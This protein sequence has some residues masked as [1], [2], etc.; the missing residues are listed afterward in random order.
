MLNSHLEAILAELSVREPIFHRREFGTSRED[1][2]NMTADDFWEIGASGAIYDRGY[3]IETLLERYQSP[4]PDDLVCSDFT[5]R[6]LAQDLYQL[7]YVL[8][9]PNRRT[10]RTTLW[11]KTNEAW[12]IVF[13]Q[14]T[15]ISE[16]YSAS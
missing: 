3:V 9:Q 1:L 11:R 5:I 8:Q 14:G 12:Q 4:E 10:R 13:H 6:Q 16:P 15:V 2:L 7:N